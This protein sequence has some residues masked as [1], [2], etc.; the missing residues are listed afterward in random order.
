MRVRVRYIVRG[1][2]I[3]ATLM[4]ALIGCN[5]E[6]GADSEATTSQTEN[7]S[8]DL[9]PYTPIVSSKGAVVDNDALQTNGFNVGI[10]KMSSDLTTAA[11]YY[12]C[13]HVTYKSSSGSWCYVDDNGDNVDVYWPSINKISLLAHYPSEGTEVSSDGTTPLFGSEVYEAYDHSNSDEDLAFK[14]NYTVHHDA[15]S[16]FDLIYALRE[17]VACPDE[18]PL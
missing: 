9:L 8:I 16:Q 4:F 18:P 5:K 12:P 2:A 6:S 15:E 3:A 13:T 10:Y 14:F 1:V 17:D 11:L 7:R